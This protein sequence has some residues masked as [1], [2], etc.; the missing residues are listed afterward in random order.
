[1]PTGKHLAKFRKVMVNGADLSNFC[2]G[3]DTPQDKERVDVSGFNAAGS[4]EFLPGLRD[5]TIT[6]SV[7]QGFG[8]GEPHQVIQPLFDSGTAFPIWIQPFGLTSDGTSAANPIFGGT[9]TC[10][11]YNGMPGELNARAELTVEFKPAPNSVFSWG[12]V[13]P[14]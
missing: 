14:T 11:S 12:T 6:L 10:F 8:S 3:T 9:A 5:D 1:M 13:A 2:F 7:L 4:R